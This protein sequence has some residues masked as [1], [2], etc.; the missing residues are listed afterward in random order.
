MG[1]TT[2]YSPTRGTYMCDA[3]NGGRDYGPVRIEDLPSDV[4]FITNGCES[5]INADFAPNLRYIILGGSSCKLI[6]ATCKNT[7]QKLRRNIQT[8]ARQVLA[9][10]KAAAKAGGGIRFKRVCCANNPRACDKE[11]RLTD[12]IGC[13]PIAFGENDKSVTVTGAHGKKCPNGNKLHFFGPAIAE[14][15][16]KVKRLS[17]MR[18]RSEASS[19]AKPKKG[20]KGK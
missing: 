6:D 8:D 9:R 19:Q 7:A 2:V 20:A 11:L 4:D 12:S 10:L 13:L 5:Y 14:V 15:W 17:E 1:G 3:N 16:D 18:S